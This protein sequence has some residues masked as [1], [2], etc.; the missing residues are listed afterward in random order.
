MK[1]SEMYKIFA[2]ISVYYPNATWAS[3]ANEA[4]I[5]AWHEMLE[6]YPFEVVSAALKRHVVNST[7]E[8][9]V[10]DILT[11]IMLMQPIK[12]KD[13]PMTVEQAWQMLMRAVRNSAYYS[14]Q[15]YNKL[16]PDIQRRTSPEDLKFL[17]TIEDDGTAL[18]VYRA[19]FMRSYGETA[20]RHEMDNMLPASVVKMMPAEE[21]VKQIAE[22]VAPVEE[23]NEEPQGDEDRA[24]KFFDLAKQIAGGKKIC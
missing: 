8:P 19:N 11:E 6:P 21:P 9:K 13:T 10:K 3:E 20:K 15:E 1:S 18:S 7:Y 16:P 12:G 14:K 2:A 4:M 17:A 22:A 24:Q 5:D 23:Q